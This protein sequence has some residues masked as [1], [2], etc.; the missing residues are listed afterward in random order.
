PN[1]EDVGY[2]GLPTTYNNCGTGLFERANPRANS[3]DLNVWE[4]FAE[5]LVPLVRDQ[6]F[7]QSLDF[8][9]AVRYADYS[10]SGGIWAWKAGLDWV[11]YDDLRL[12]GTLSRDVRA[13]TLSERFDFSGSGATVDDTITGAESVAVSVDQ[14]GNPN[15]D[16]EKADTLTF[17]A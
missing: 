4:A 1:A 9:G 17:G 16:P 10:G 2:K 5:A 14:T 7:M 13:G 11:V 12:R 6:P 8:Q 3:G 15:I